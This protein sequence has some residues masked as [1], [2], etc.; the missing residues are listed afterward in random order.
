MCA[1]RRLGAAPYALCRVATADSALFGYC[2]IYTP[3]IWLIL[4][5]HDDARGAED[6]PVM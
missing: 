2:H 5:L 4:T 6:D 1:C 3:D